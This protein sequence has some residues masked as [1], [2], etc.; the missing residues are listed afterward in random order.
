[1]SGEGVTVWC[2]SI[3]GTPSAVGIRWSA[4]EA[5]SSAPGFQY[6][7]SSAAV[8]TACTPGRAFAAATSSAVMAACA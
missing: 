2:S 5:F 4:S 1:L 8:I 6:S 3:R 7:P